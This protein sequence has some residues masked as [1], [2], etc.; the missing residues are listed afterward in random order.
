LKKVGG[1]MFETMAIP[2]LLKAVEFLFEEGKKILEER[3]ERRKTQPEYEKVQ[4]TNISQTEA[5]PKNVE[6]IETKEEALNT[7]INQFV[8]KASETKV[9]HLLTLLET[10]TRNYYL[11]KEQYAQFGRAYV[12]PIIVNN[13]EEA[14]AQIETTTIELKSVL[15][16]IYDKQISI[17]DI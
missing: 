9:K 8:W 6:V 2:I 4:P 16:K 12:P 5:P 7:P 17:P 15:S 3:R 14:E 1:T 11:A 13:L 10:Y